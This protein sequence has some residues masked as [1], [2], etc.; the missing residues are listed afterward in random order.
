MGSPQEVIDRTLG[1]RE[2]VGD[3]QCQGFLVDHA[4]LP[5]KTVLE[6]LDMLGEI[7]P[8][9]RRE[10]A[11]MRAPSVPEAPTH[12]AR[13]AALSKKTADKVG[14]AVDDVTGA[15]FYEQ[16]DSDEAAVRNADQMLRAMEND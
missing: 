11:A 1:F 4:G 9:M 3:Y 8:V 10:F 5:L 13:V 15:S 6:Q 14:T 2:H 12:A 16:Q 7:L